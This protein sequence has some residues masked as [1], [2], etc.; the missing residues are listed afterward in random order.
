MK[1][2][3]LFFVSAQ[4]NNLYSFFEE[5]DNQEALQLLWKLEQECC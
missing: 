1:H 2:D 3:D 4:M 5:L